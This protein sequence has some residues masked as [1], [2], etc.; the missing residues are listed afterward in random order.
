[1]EMSASVKAYMILKWAGDSLAAP[2]MAQTRAA[3]LRHG[4]ITKCNTFTK[5]YLAM[6]GLYP[7][8]GCPAIPPELILLPKWFSF[9][10]YNMSAWSRAM[11]VPLSVIRS[12]EPARPMRSEWNIDELWANRDIRLPRDEGTFTW[13][14]FF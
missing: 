1:F 11:L 5:I 9:S 2:H 12:T 7:W 13:H 14:N 3:I 8:D 10:I 4:G 6:I